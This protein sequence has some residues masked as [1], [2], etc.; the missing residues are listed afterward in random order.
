[1][2]TSLKL[3]P[4][5]SLSYWRFTRLKKCLM[6]GAFPGAVEGIKTPLV[7]AGRP[8]VLGQIY[9]SVMEVFHA[10]RGPNETQGRQLREAFNSV[11]ANQTQRIR[12]DPRLRHLGDPRQWKEIAEIY[13]NLS[14]LLERRTS[15][16]SNVGTEIL[17]EKTLY[18]KDSV[19]FGQIDAYFVHKAGI[20]LADYKSG[21][22]VDD[23]DPKHD[24][25]N[26]LYFYAYLIHE[27]YAVYPRSLSLIGKDG[28]CISVRPS[29]D[30]SLELANEA[31]SLLF[32]YN[33]RI[34][35]GVRSD[36]LSNPSSDN[37]TFCDAKPICRKFWQEARSLNLPNW[38]HIVEGTQTKPLARSK[39]GASMI[40]LD[41][42]NS[43][44][45]CRTIKIGRLFEGRFPDLKDRVGQN[46]IFTNLRFFE[47]STMPM[48]E[49]TDRTSILT[50][51]MEV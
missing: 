16:A 32:R 37:C 44:I 12:E 30:R 15:A 1:M 51:E 39:M 8:Q 45:P 23:E 9:H 35:A 11:I 28:S 20:D 4:I 46:L 29:I 40:E 34:K 13:S 47:S 38:A 3:K 18:S 24:Y 7:S 41:V 22:M 43:S 26:Q 27:N 2:L 36:E 21:K 50:L 49:T 31:R 5:K 25:S 6:S 10:I 48:A 17:T 42:R 19:L 33:D 14:D